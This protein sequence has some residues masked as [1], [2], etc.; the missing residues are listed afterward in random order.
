[1]DPEDSDTRRTTGKIQVRVSRFYA[2]RSDPGLWRRH[3]P[4]DW[5]K[6]LLRACERQK[7]PLLGGVGV[8]AV[9]VCGSGW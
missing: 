9:V 8:P 6:E 1:M 5:S 4:L 3:P 2:D 7:R